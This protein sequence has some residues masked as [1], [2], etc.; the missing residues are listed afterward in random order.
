MRLLRTEVNR[1]YLRAEWERYQSDP[2]IIGIT[3]VLSNNHTTLINGKPVPFTDICDELQGNYPKWFLFEG[4]HP[5]CRCTMLPII[6]SSEELGQ[7]TKLMAE[8]KE[9]QFKSKNEVTDLPDNFKK[10]LNDNKTRIDAASQRGT[11]PYW[12]RDNEGVIKGIHNI[13]GK[14]DNVNKLTMNAIIDPT[15]RVFKAILRI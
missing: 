12:L 3:I 11:L 1:A 15:G 2:Q 9:S 4:W 10:W 5:Q 8:G 14:E 13:A 6:I 7:Y